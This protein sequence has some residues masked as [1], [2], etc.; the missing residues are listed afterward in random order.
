[1][2]SSSRQSGLFGVQDW[3]TLYQ[4]FQQADFK[5]YDYETLRKVFIDYLRLQYPEQFNDY[6][7]SSEFIALLDII[8]FMGQGLA[9]RGDLNA[10][11]NFID[12]AERRES[13]IKLA[14]LVSY[15]PK[16]NTTAEGFLKVTSISTTENVR[17]INGI[18]LSNQVI[19]W[20][21]PANADWQE[22]FNSI[23]NAALIDSQRIGRPG[24]SQ[25]V[26][27]VQTEEYSIRINDTALPIAP[28][29]AEVDAQRMRFELVS[30]S[31]VGRDYVYEVPPAPN[32]RFNILY[33]NDQL[34]FGSPQTGFFFLFKQGTLQTFDFSLENRIPNQI[35]D[36]GTI[37]GVN[38]TDTW[39]YQRN[40]DGTR[41]EWREVENIYT[42][43]FTQENSED[44]RLFSVN[45]R[46]DD[47]VSYVFGDGV[48]SEI[49]LGNFRSYVRGG[50]AQTYTIEPSEMLGI[51]VA[52]DYLDRNGRRATLTVGLTLP[53]TVSNAQEAE[54]LD[55]IKRRA[56]TRFY[57]QNR[58][59][60]GEDYNNFPFTYYNS[61]IK[62]KAI[63]RSS[64]GVSKNL[65]L[66][67]PTG[68]FSSTNTFSEDGA[69]FQDDAQGFLD[70]VINN[71]SDIISFFNEILSNELGSNRATQ[72]YITYYPRYNIDQQS[73][74]GEVFWRTSSVDSGSE[75]GYLFT[76]NGSLELPVSVGTFNS[77]NLKYV[78]R[79][80]IVK[81]VAPAGSYFDEN[82]RLVT[83]V[84][85][86]DQATFIFTTV[87][88]VIGD[89]SNNGRGG[90][91]NGTGPIRVNGYV[92]DGVQIES[93]IPVFDNFLPESVVREAIF[94]I[95]LQQDF[96]LIF[97]NSLPIN[98]D[99]WFVESE[100]EEN[101]F[102][103]FTNVGA[104]RYNVTFRQ[105]GYFFGSVAD[106][107]FSYTEG[108]LIFDPFTGQAIQDFINIPQINGQ[109]TTNVPLQTNIKVN[110]I[111]QETE[112]DGFFNDS[113]VEVGST[114]LNNTQLILNPDFFEDVTGWEPN[115]NNLGKYVFFETVQDQFNLSRE[116]II[117]TA[118]VVFT[119]PTL[120]VIETVKYDYPEGQLF[121]AYEDDKFYTT[122]QDPFVT[123][124]SY[125]VVEQTQYSQRAGRQGLIFQYS[126][127]ASNQYRI[128]PATTNI[129]DTYVV[130]QNYYTAYTNWI[131][132][133]TDTI[134]QPLK[135]TI[136]ELSNDY[137]ELNDFKMLS[138]TV[139][140]NSVVFKPLFGAKADPALQATIKVV[141]DSRV[142]ASDSEVITEVVNT[143]NEYFN[144][145]N[146]DFGDTFYFSELSAYLHSEIGEFISSVVLVPTDPTKTFGDLYEIRSL[147]YEIFVN[148]ATPENIQIVPALTPD[149]LQA[150]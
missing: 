39:L 38:N 101:Y 32:G 91:P 64:I 142:N 74:D 83:G 59:V 125:T 68:K 104:N 17:D 71:T 77:F 145:N 92:P 54:S 131:Q 69:L 13:V 143:M 107:R 149:E 89:G 95:E 111:G 110:I 8:S 121:Y 45:S 137:G 36:I 147:P 148:G 129:I 55:D 1:M 134:V 138:D 65:D 119:Y 82:N 28:F 99:R 22:Q 63:N 16:R 136:N 43:S 24:N 35:V 48:F 84:P 33:R 86:S 26:L 94:R 29:N 4:T 6:T 60:N 116:Y 70:L 90:F 47:Q 87:L 103:R 93:V 44:K 114:D 5:S 146:W 12:T 139:V 81:F 67:D 100:F 102:V 15:Q 144:I 132:D 11:E 62:S 46:N 57:T 130:P 120:A 53:L 98:Q 2:P 31:S 61:I 150:G 49:P 14:N 123:T 40:N 108:D 133:T 105:L 34:G 52:F 115:S 42:S 56:P 88:N 124:I 37:N 96:T 78:T 50:N 27:G 21:D 80:A 3:T 25:N 118:D 117:P 20:N 113:T 18:N 97:D 140:L 126:H 23:I 109:A 58:M 72:Y 127:V 106:V 51:N 73:G 75:T 122:Q 76:Q 112:S 9:F 135:P 66:L 85:P 19:L 41:T 128:D 10:R 7:E 79:G 30:G 141:K